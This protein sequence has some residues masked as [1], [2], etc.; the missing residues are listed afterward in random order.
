[1]SDTNYLLFIGESTKTNETIVD[2]I[3]ID[4]PNIEMYNNLY[5]TLMNDKLNSVTYDELS[6]IHDEISK[7]YKNIKFKFDVI[8]S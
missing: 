1:M 3:I 4:I 5:T 8:I 2:M 7:H 6:I